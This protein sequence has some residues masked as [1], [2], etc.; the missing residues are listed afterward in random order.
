VS[1]VMVVLYVLPLAGFIVIVAPRALF[2]A[3]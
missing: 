1:V 3:R 2:I